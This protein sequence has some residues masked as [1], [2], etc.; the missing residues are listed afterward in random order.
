MYAK[1]HV[2]LVC[3][4]NEFIFLCDY[5]ALEAQT[6][7]SVLVEKLEPKTHLDD[8]NAIVTSQG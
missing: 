6:T 2:Y 7:Y 3:K 1:V 5:R 8:S 4:P